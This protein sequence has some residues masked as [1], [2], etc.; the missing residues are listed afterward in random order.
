M[1]TKITSATRVIALLGDPVAHSLSPAI[2]NAAFTHAETDG[3][4]V[5]VRCGGDDLMGFM[6]GLARAGGGGN[7]TLPHKEKAAALLDLPSD[8]VRRTGACNTFWG[9]RDGKVHGDNTDVA[10]FRGALSAFLEGSPRGIRVLLLGAGGAARAALTGL[11]EE[12]ADEVVI[13][14]R[15]SERARAVARRIGGERVRVSSV[16]DELRDQCFDL[17]VNA[18]RLGLSPDDPMPLNF[19]I[20]GRAGAAID[21]VYGREA[22]SFV[23]AAE[24]FG[25]RA[26]DGAEML[27]RQGAASFERWWRTPAPLEVMRAAMLE[28]RGP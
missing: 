9:D 4:Y 2:Q 6:R 1:T 22:T 23:Q 24:S 8:A 10:G 27:V 16:V 26:T 14:N 12:G 11:L 28:S 25:V 5:A 3:V 18:T 13:H 21:L 15:S 19:E 20:L 7:I 17:V